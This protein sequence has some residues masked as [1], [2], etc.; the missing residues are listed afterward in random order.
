MDIDTLPH[1]ME[2]SLREPVKHTS[3][4]STDV[5]G[6]RHPRCMSSE[7]CVTIRE[8]WDWRA[9]VDERARPLAQNRTGS[10][11]CALRASF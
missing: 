4:P 8:L 1:F 2:Y 6:K 10:L 9:I 3:I 5:D 11:A 7:Y